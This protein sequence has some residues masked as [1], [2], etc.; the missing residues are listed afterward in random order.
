MAVGRAARDPVIRRTHDGPPLPV[1]S[2]ELP[3]DEAVSAYDQ[4]GKRAEDW[5]KV[6]LRPGHAA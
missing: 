3:L 1:I 5:T 2:H 6:I 4:F